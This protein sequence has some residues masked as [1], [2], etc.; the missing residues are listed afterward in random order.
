[1]PVRVRSSEGLGRT[2]CGNARP[3]VPED[4]IDGQGNCGYI[5]IEDQGKHC[6]RHD[7]AKG[8]EYGP[9]PMAAATL[10]PTQ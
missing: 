1:M 6:R 5:D 3:Q 4:Q 9:K 2:A 8:A 7:A 10:D